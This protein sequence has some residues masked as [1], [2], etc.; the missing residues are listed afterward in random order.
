MLKV[1]NISYQVK[2]RKILDSVSAVFPTGKINLIIGPNGAGKTTLLK[3]LSNQLKPSGGSVFY[4][5]RKSSTFSTLELAKIRAVLSQNIEVCFP[6]TVQ[7]VVMMGRYPHFTNKPSQQDIEACQTTM[8]LFEISDLAQQQYGTLSGGEK[9]RTHFARVMA[10]IFYA[11]PH[12]S[13]YLILDEPL[14]FLDV[15]YQF[16][17]MHRLKELAQ[18]EDITIIGVVHDLNMAARFADYLI[19]LNHGRLMISGLPEE[20]LTVENITGVYKIMPQILKR[21]EGISVFF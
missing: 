13:R 9:Q 18:Q 17:F 10:Q 11:V 19:L 3:I 15:Y 4:G 14:T 7:E 16:E 21:E 20:V 1:Q 12:Y 5:D 2:H 8:R 6:L